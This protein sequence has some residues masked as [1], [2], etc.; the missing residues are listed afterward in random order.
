M[1]RITAETT[2]MFLNAVDSIF[3]SPIYEIVD[4]AEVENIKND[5]VRSCINVREPLIQVILGQ[6]REDIQLGNR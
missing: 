6:K 5:F 2:D 4:E 1:S 3:Y